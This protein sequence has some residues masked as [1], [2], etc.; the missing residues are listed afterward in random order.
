MNKGERDELLI[1]IKLLAMQQNNKLIPGL[2]QIKS[3]SNYNKVSNQS[4]L[5]L[6]K[7]INQS[8][9]INIL[10]NNIE[11]YDN[12][13]LNDLSIK[14]GFEKTKSSAKSDILINNA[15]VSLK[16]R[17]NAP[18]ALVNHTTRPGFEFASQICGGNM[19]ELD[20][21]IN[22]YWLLRQKGK[23][24]Q[25][26]KSNEMPF[27]EKREIIKPFLNYFL[28]YGSG[29]KESDY[30][31]KFI[32]SFDSPFLEDSWE[33]FDESNAIEHYWDKLVFS[34]RSK[35]MPTRYPLVSKR[36]IEKKSSIDKWTRFM[37]N[38]YKGS[39]HIRSA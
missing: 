9:Q 38:N 7:D 18:P 12:K 30:P 26:I 1:K 33:I 21:I 13:R 25:D 39:L 35:G 17:R 15:G 24:R 4:E 2:G 8:N 16:S 27:K 20:K 22:D 11:N 19:Y 5:V 32:L 34:I 37:N 31:A 36:M 14:L 6:D 3:L 28:F 10:L 29:S 23:I